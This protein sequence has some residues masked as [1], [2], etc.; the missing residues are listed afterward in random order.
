MK[1]FF[2]FSVK[3]QSAYNQERALMNDSWCWQ[4]FIEFELWESSIYSRVVSLASAY[5]H[6]LIR[7]FSF[8]LS[9]EAKVFYL[10][11]MWYSFRVNFITNKG[12]TRTLNDERAEFNIRVFFSNYLLSRIVWK[13]KL[14]I[15]N[16]HG[17]NAFTSLG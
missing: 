10:S 5:I 12:Q 13:K 11:V 1:L 8:P 14:F 6:P 16:S 4:H 15:W 7:F 9:L 3:S 2:F 17:N